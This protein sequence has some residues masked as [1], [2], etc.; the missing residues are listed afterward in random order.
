[1]KKMLKLLIIVLSAVVMTACKNL[2]KNEKIGIDDIEWE[3]KNG[4]VYGE[5]WAV[6]SFT[7]NSK[8]NIWELEIELRPKK[9]F[10]GS[11]LEEFYAYFQEEY[12]LTSEDMEYYIKDAD[13]RINCHYYGRY[14]DDMPLKP[15]AS[16]DNERISYYGWYYAHNIEWIDYF[17]PYIAT[18]VYEDDGYIYTVYFDYEEGEYTHDSTVETLEEYL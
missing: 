5:K 18:I 7:N 1:M 10:K 16:I 11:K 3:L 13:L 8:Y 14:N 6:I 12:D 2:H 15:G 17:E 4:I 9:N